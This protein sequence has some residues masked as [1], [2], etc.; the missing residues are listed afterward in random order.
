MQIAVIGLGRMGGNIARRLIARGHEVVA[1]ARNPDAAR[2]IENA[3]PSTDLKDVVSKLKSPRAIWV[4]LP[5][6]GPTEENIN[7]L[8]P[9]LAK[10]DIIIDGGNTFFKDD[11]RRAAALRERGIEYVDVGTSGGI[12]GLQRGYCMMIGG[13]KKVVEH[14]DPIFAALAPGEG[15]IPK[16][17]RRERR[18]PRVEKGY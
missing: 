17:P 11:V 5:A 8:V 6:G 4:M 7:V 3:I 1:Y 12:W 13:E 14:L 15:T 2:A 16:T 10:G 9:L 18:D